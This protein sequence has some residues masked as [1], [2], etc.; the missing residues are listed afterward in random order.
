MYIRMHIQSEEEASLEFLSCDSKAGFALRSWRRII[1]GLA[2]ITYV[3]DYEDRAGKR[4]NVEVAKERK[5]WLG[6]DDHLYQIF[7]LHKP[8]SLIV[9]DHSL[10]PLES[11]PLPPSVDEQTSFP[12]MIFAAMRE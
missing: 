7:W 3:V 9:L 1:E 4:N 8:D 12:D 10:A 5:S 6:C 11:G 2:P